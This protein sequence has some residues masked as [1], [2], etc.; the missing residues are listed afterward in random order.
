MSSWLTRYNIRTILYGPLLKRLC[1]IKSYI[2]FIFLHHLWVS[3]VPF[4]FTSSHKPCLIVSSSSP[5]LLP[6]NL[7]PWRW[8]FNKYWTSDISWLWQI[9]LAHFLE[10][11]LTCKITFLL[12]SGLILLYQF[13]KGLVF[14]YPLYLILSLTQ[15]FREQTRM[16]MT[17]FLWSSYWQQFCFSQ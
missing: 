6:T 7:L 10:R 11:A 14:W 9:L 8:L 3:G 15:K 16:H 13:K 4:S 12:Q 1:Y 2:W 5:P 17:V